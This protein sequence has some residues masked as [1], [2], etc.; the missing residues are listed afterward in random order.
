MGNASPLIM[1]LLEEPHCYY[2]CYYHEYLIASSVPFCRKSTWNFV[3]K[4]LLELG[5][6]RGSS[7]TPDI[8]DARM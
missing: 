4:F 7:L 1:R 3:G 6:G 5:D 2:H 8:R